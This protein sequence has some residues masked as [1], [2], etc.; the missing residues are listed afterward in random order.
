[1]PEQVTLTTPVTRT[2]SAW[3]V[4]RIH[5]DLLTGLIS[6][7]LVGTDSSQMLVLY[8]TPP[9]LDHPSQPTGATLL[10]ALNTSN[11]TTTSLMKRT[12]LQLQAD[13]YLPAGSVTG[14]PD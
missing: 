2:L 11:N 10:H 9:P 13:G 12:M 7:E 5:L 6:V 4:A 14:T 3:K 1:M 8:P